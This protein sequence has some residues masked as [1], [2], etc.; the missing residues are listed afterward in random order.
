MWCINVV[1]IDFI[2]QAVLAILWED[3]LPK[4]TRGLVNDNFEGFEGMRGLEV[5]IDVRV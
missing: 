3:I 1:V 2:N 4:A 5:R